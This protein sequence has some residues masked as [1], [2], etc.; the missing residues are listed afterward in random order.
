[1]LNFLE[2]GFR[3]LVTGIDVG[4]V[5]SRE[6]PVRLFDGVGRRVASH[7]QNLVIIAIWHRMPNPDRLVRYP[8]VPSDLAYD[9]WSAAARR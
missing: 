8:P 4:M 6:P 5:L 3:R 9:A 1:M 7:P 2:A